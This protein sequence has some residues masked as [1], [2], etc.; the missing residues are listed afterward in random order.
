MVRGG[1]FAMA[2]TVLI[3]FAVGAAM[4]AVLAL[5]GNVTRT[6]ALIVRQSLAA[7]D[8]VSNCA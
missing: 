3:F 7:V 2:R 4:S 1:C 5:S 6:M 8:D